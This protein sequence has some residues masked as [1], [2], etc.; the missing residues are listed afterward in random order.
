[1]RILPDTPPTADEAFYARALGVMTRPGRVVRTIGALA[2]AAF[3]LSVAAFVGFVGAQAW[4]RSQLP[5]TYLRAWADPHRIGP[6]EPVK[7]WVSIVRHKRCA[8]A[9]TWSVTDSRSMVSYFGPVFQQ[10]PGDTSPTPQ[11]PYG[12]DYVTPP[13]MAPGPATLRVTLRGECPGNYL[14]NWWPV[15]ID[16]PPVP[17]DVAAPT[18]DLAPSHGAKP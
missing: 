10:A 3:Y 4:D 17:F 18:H 8:Y 16:M 2:N 1:M 13:V 9:V 6:G 15:T 11:A 14:D 5:F 7:V 12:L